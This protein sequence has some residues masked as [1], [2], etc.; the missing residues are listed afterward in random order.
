MT[1]EGRGVNLV[2]REK[3]PTIL[4]FQPTEF[5]LVESDKLQEFEENLRNDVGLNNFDLRA[6]GGGTTCRCPRQ[7][8]DC[9]FANLDF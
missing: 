9:D 2:G 5:E 7:K 1:T 4:M 3:V 6:V 8:D